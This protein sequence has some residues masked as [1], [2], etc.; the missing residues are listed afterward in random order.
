MVTAIATTQR[1]AC[2]TDSTHQERSNA[3]SPNVHRNPLEIPF[4]LGMSSL[5]YQKN[6]GTTTPGLPLHSRACSSAGCL[7]YI[8]GNVTDERR[9][10]GVVEGWRS[11]SDTA[12]GSRHWGTAAVGQLLAAEITD[13]GV[14]E[15][16][17]S[18]LAELSTPGVKDAA[19]HSAATAAAAHAPVTSQRL[20]YDSSCGEVA[21]GSKDHKASVGEAEISQSVKL[22]TLDMED[23][24]EYSVATA[25]AAAAHRFQLFSRTSKGAASSRRRSRRVRASKVARN[26]FPAGKESSCSTIRSA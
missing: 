17:T 11:D 23:A 20:V 15:A 14:G 8:C 18:Q 3:R 2:T 12:Q 4:R 9:D 19:E 1:S 5:K 21:R 16:G 26:T 13:P 22:S 10:G 25:A 6:T 24:T 7:L